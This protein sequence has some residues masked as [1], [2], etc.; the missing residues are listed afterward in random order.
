MCDTLVIVR[1]EGVLF[2]KNSDRDP[3]ESQYLDWHPRRVHPPGVPLQCTWIEIPQAAETYAVLL[4]RPFWI[5]GA[6]MGTNEHGVTIGNEAVFTRQRTAKTGLTGMDLVRLALERSRSAAGAVQMIVNLIGEF[7]QG[8]ACSLLERPGF[9]YHNSFIVADPASAFVLETAAKQHAVEEVRAARSISNGL[10][11]PGFAK[12]HS[13]FIKTRVCGCRVRQPRTQRLA[14]RAESPAD[15]MRILR[16]HGAGNDVPK[17]SWLNGGLGAPCVHAGGLVASSQT[18]ASWVADLRPGKIAHWVTGTAAPCTS[19]F[20]PV[21]ID[22]PLELGPTPCERADDESPWWRHERLHRAVMRDPA[23]LGARYFAER[24]EI[25]SAWLAAPPDSCAAFE[26][27]ARLE[28][29]WTADV[30]FDDA[31][32]TRPRFVARYWAE[33]NA[34]AGLQFKTPAPS[35]A[36]AVRT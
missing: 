28:A 27:A 11:I 32:E 25:E 23:R 7:G 1:S 4:S 12:R 34:R 17:Y 6:E 14:E 13:D 30:L 31:G 5:W 15:L 18:T 19:L 26:E 10:T 21:S 29:K 33:R 22:R 2:A 9:T 20:K 3:N 35:D 24:D 8:G 16:D 36:Q